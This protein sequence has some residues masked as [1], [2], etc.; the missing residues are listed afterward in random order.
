MSLD[1]QSALLDFIQT[2]LGE[3]ASA[4]VPASSDASFRRYWRVMR[5]SD[6]FIVMDAPPEKENCAPFIDISQR[7]VTAGI[8]ALKICFNLKLMM[9]IQ[10]QLFLARWEFL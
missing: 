9:Q 1:R 5:G 10:H 8:N 4:P 2:R 7:L 3:T 6:S